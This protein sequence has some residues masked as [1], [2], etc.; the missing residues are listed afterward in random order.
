MFM[1]YAD[2]WV[3]TLTQQYDDMY[4]K[5]DVHPPNCIRVNM[6]VQQFQQFFDTFGVAE[7]DGMWLAPDDRVDIW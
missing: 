7:G 6:T 3:G 2:S 4:M 5:P 1:E